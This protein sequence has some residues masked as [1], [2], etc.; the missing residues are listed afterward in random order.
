MQ[1]GIAHII[2]RLHFQKL[3]PLIQKAVGSPGQLRAWATDEDYNS[4][5]A[6]SNFM[7]AYRSEAAQQTEYDR[8][9]DDLKNRIAQVQ[10]Q[11]RTQL[12]SSIKIKRQ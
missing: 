5:V 8:L 2:Q 9:P 12:K 4:Q 7:R 3:P 1:F 6:S 11:V 10:M